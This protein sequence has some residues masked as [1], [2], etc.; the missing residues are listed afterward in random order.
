MSY[1]LY[2]ITTGSYWKY[3][4]LSVDFIKSFFTVLAGAWLVI[5]LAN[6]SHWVDKE[7]LRVE[8][9]L[10]IAF[11][12]V[13]LNRIPINKICYKVPGKDLRF[14]VRIGDMFEIPGQK[15]ISTNT[16][17]DTEDEIIAKNSLQGQ[18]T[19]KYYSKNIGDLDKALE[20]ALSKE[21]YNLLSTKSYGKTK[22]YSM[23][24]VAKLTCGNEYFYWVAMSKLND[25]KTASSDVATI[26]EI[27][28]KL[29]DFF[30]KKGEVDTIISPL[31]GTGKG[32]I[33]M[34]RKK[35]IEEIFQSFIDAVKKENRVFSNCLIIVVSR[36]DAIDHQINLYEIEA[37][38]KHA[39]VH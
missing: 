17:F 35:M 11:F 36:K 15:I 34:T 29:W 12:I 26:K 33:N 7:H 30:I 4:I 22:E 31:L 25:S 2:S 9:V 28:P 20:T 5:E 18:F 13:V 27:L 38:L 1:F 8:V 23:G 6:C 32:R 3:A 14:E 19:E 39:L 16:T 37:Y 21:E 24:T 10:G